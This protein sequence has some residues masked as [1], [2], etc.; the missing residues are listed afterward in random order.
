MANYKEAFD[1]RS[2][3]LESKENQLSIF[4][5]SSI[6]LLALLSLSV[7]S[8]VYL[9]RVS[10]VEPFLVSVDKR[11]GE[12]ALPQKLQVKSF[13]PTAQMIR[14]FTKTF[15]NNWESY[16]AHHIN[17]PYFDVIAMS[18]KAVAMHYRKY[19]LKGENP[20]SPINKLGRTK[21]RTVK[22]HSI[23]KLGNP[24]TLDIRYTT[25]TLESATDKVVET[26]EKRAVLN[27]EIKNIKRSLEAW[28]ANPIGFV[29]THIDIQNIN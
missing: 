24:K 6:V 16:N 17:K 22:I 13:T 5:I 9:A 19:I 27:W 1:F 7:M 28:D 21:Y 3:I 2:A 25:T 14:H 18:D 8:N 10:H 26:R 20:N 11:T 4:R 29:V 12:I 23:S 15:I